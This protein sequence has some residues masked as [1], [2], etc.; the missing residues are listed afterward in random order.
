[1]PAVHVRVG[2]R[3]K[4]GF[5]LETPMDELIGFFWWLVRA[6][7]ILIFIW[8]V[9]GGGGPVCIFLAGCG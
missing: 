5:R 6:A 2:F 7:G 9:S 1:M 3:L 4:V 8:L